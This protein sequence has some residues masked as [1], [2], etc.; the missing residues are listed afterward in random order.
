MATTLNQILL[1]DGSF[2]WL[3]SGLYW[4]RKLGATQL[5]PKDQFQPNLVDTPLMVETDL[6]A[7]YDIKRW[8]QEALGRDVLE[9]IHYAYLS[10]DPSCGPIVYQALSRLKEI[11]GQAINNYADP[12]IFPLLALYRKVARESHLFLGLIRFEAISGHVYYATFE[13]TYD[14]LPILAPHFE[15]RLGNQPWIIH[16]IKRHRAALYDGHH[17]WIQALNQPQDL[18]RSREE[19][20]F[21]SLWQAYYHHIAIESRKNLRLKQK[22]M[23]KKYW[24]HLTEMKT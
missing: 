1:Y 7:A 23:P 21:K 9:R 14:L 3:L 19:V 18:L 4:Q 16:D 2:E 17:F 6:K 15:K 11:G 24:K 10:E 12:L 22:M 13:P 8:I 20:D 5:I